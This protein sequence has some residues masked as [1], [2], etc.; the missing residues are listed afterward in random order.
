MSIERNESIRFHERG[1]LTAVTRWMAAHHEGIAE[2]FK[3]VR[4]Q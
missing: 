3:N 2:W 4:R 1:T